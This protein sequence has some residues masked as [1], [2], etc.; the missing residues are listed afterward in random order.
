[1]AKREL[2][3]VVIVAVAQLTQLALVGPADASHTVFDYTVRFELIGNVPGSFADEFNDGV[4]FPWITIRGNAFEANGLLHLASPG[5]DTRAFELLNP[6]IL[7][8]VTD[9]TPP[10]V[11]GVA[12]N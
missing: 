8:D 1:M 9:V 7:L 10:I 2:R 6:A 3:V 11:V 12:G 4:V 5:V